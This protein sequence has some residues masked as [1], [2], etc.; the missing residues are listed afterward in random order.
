M[1][2]RVLQREALYCARE[3]TSDT[4]LWHARTMDT[5]Q[6]DYTIARGMRHATLCARVV[7][8]VR[9]YIERTRGAWRRCAVYFANLCC[10]AAVSCGPLTPKCIQ[11]SSVQRSAAQRSA[12]QVARS[13]VG[14]RP[15]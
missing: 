12:A 11:V 14:P 1:R 7:Q 5:C 13:A 10:A 9:L 4:W 3:H 15:W 6:L 2:W 8:G